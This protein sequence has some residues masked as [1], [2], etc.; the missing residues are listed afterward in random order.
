VIYETY[1]FFQ[2]NYRILLNFMCDSLSQKNVKTH[3]LCNLEILT[4]LFFSS[5]PRLPNNFKL[6]QNLF[7]NV[8]D[9][10][11]LNPLSNKIIHNMN[12]P[13]RSIKVGLVQVR[14]LRRSFNDLSAIVFCDRVILTL[15]SF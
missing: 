4:S 1:G 7:K 6:K 9:W 11:K 13:Y 12:K 5:F 10:V 8:W 15:H 14:A 2:L 3:S